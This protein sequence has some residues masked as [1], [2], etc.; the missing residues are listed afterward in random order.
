MAKKIPLRQCI[1]CRESKPKSELIR[2]IRTPE[3]EICFDKTGRMNG[4]GAYIC[5]SKSCLDKAFK[6]KGIERALNCEIPDKIYETLRG[7]DLIDEK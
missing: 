6:S 1:G 4:R 7:V 5:P 3:N 2:I